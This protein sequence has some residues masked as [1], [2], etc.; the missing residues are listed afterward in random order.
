MPQSTQSLTNPVRASGA[1]TDQIWRRNTNRKHNTSATHPLEVGYPP[2]ALDVL[3]VPARSLWQRSQRLRLQRLQRVGQLALP[4]LDARSVGG[5]RQLVQ[6][7]A[8]EGVHRV[9]VLRQGLGAGGD[10]KGGGEKM[11]GQQGVGTDWAR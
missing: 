9:C 4:Q 7:C 3:D 10:G 11:K 6:L 8:D 1:E 2:D 5:P